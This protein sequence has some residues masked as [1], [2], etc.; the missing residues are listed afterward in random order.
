MATIDPDDFLLF[1]D[2]RV[3]RSTAPALLCRIAGKTVWL[4]RRHIAGNL[5]CAG[6]RGKLSIRRWIALDR[7]LIHPPG[8]VAVLSLVPPPSERR[9]PPQLHLVRGD[10]ARGMATPS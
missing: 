10:R 5:W 7:Q 9:L 6:D 3:L 2:V 8:T 1:K 4:P